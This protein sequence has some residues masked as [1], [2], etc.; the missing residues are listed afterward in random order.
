MILINIL[1]AYRTKYVP[2]NQ[3]KYV[4]N[5]DSIHCRSLWERRVCKFC[6]VNENIVKWSFEEIMVPYHNPVDN[7]IRNYIPD[8]LVQIKNNDQVE[9][10]MIEVKPKKQ[11]MLKEN[12]S[13]SQPHQNNTGIFANLHVCLSFAGKLINQHVTHTGPFL[14][15]VV[16]VYRVS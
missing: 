8:F 15:E 16:L 6:D 12:A 2:L 4:G 11:T 9:S 5:P 7:K 10:W 13:H 14:Y 3:Q 1:M